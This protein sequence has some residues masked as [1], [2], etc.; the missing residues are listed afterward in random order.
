MTVV[1]EGA[2]ISDLCLIR[3]DYTVIINCVVTKEE[4]FFFFN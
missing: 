1:L 3:D 4:L 2:F